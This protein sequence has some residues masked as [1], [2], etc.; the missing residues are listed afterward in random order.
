MEFALLLPL[1]LLILF[2]TIEFGRLFSTSLVLNNAARDGARIAAVGAGDGEV[3]DSV[4][5]GCLSLGDGARDQIEITVQ[6][7]DDE[8]ESG[9]MVTVG[10]CYSLPLVTPVLSDL[11]PNPFPLTAECIMRVE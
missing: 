2:G 5:A 4:L 10:L 3:V 6:P 8:R 9:G 11:V 1:L 7:G